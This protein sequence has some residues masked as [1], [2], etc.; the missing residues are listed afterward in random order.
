MSDGIA[1][2]DDNGVN[3]MH[4]LRGH[5]KSALFNPVQR[6]PGSRCHWV[7]DNA[8]PAGDVQKL[9]VHISDLGCFCV[10]IM[11]IQTIVQREWLLTWPN[12]D[13]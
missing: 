2:K 13:G 9:L 7:T 8:L 11:N 4:H 1:I 10:A 12:R 5:K 6:P 3:T